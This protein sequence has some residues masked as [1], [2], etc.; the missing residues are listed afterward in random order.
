MRESASG[1]AWLAIVLTEARIRVRQVKCSLSESC[2]HR[3]EP[4]LP[5]FILYLS[6][7]IFFGFISDFEK[8]FLNFYSFIFRGRGKE[9]ETGR[10]TSMYE[11]NINLWPL[12][13]PQPGTQ[14]AT[15]A[16][17]LTRN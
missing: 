9:G 14:A 10:E 6:W 3:L 4:S 1:P 8:Y 2:K 12:A 17:T 13:H 7:I 16:C 15:Q 5:I 11:R